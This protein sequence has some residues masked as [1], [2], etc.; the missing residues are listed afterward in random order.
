LHARE[1][2]RYIIEQ[3]QQQQFIMNIDPAAVALVAAIAQ[4][5][6]GVPF[7]A[8][9]TVAPTQGGVPA[10]AP[11]VPDAPIQGRQSNIVLHGFTI[12]GIDA[13]IDAVG[14]EHLNVFYAR[15]WIK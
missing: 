2:E 6:T 8:P 15:L 12:E 11:D 14:R 3:Q 9:E 13:A 4:G 5:Y 7:H 1:K 10:D